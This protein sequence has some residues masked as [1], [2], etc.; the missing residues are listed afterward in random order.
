MA[1]F[2]LIPGAMHGG[3][4]WERIVPLLEAAGHEAVAPDLPGMGANRS[5]A[6][7]QVTGALG[8]LRGRVGARG[9]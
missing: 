5:V 1:S 8:R 7:D 9:P 6:F 2:V 3:W 4:T